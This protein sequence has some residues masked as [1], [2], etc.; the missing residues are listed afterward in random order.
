MSTA[1]AR[2]AHM[3]VTGGAGFIGS[4]L[5]DR[6]VD[7]GHEVTV[8]DS[9][10]SGHNWITGHIEAGRVRFIQADLLDA[11]RL[12][13]AMKGTSVVWH[14]G[15]N[16]DIPSGVNRPDLDLQNAIVATHNVLEAMRAHGVGR[17]VFSSTGAIYGEAEVD[18]IPENYG[19]LLPLS[20][21]AAGKLAA[22]GL[23]ASYC[24]LFGFRARMF[25]FGNVVGARMSHGVTYD[26]IVKLLRN[27]TELEILGDGQ[28]VKS[29]FL[30]EEC[31]DGMFFVVEK[32]FAGD[33]PAVDLLNLGAG[34][35]TTVMDIARIVIE[36]LGLTDVKFR[37]TGGRQG[38]PGD[39]PR[40]RLDVARVNRLGW[41]ARAQ[42]SEAVR[43]AARRIIADLKK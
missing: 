18:P 8:Y 26:F 1:L 31:L 15:G 2:G 35:A 20:L 10:V 3:L 27:P 6:L 33:G 12:R 32:A 16:T 24:S 37:F 36:E 34:E 43:V 11:D 4:H 38:W 39:Q 9:L 30:V 28:G 42:S 22:E 13:S 23:I 19:P 17:L 25:R 29:Y 41:K 21:Y 40:V 14:L 5:V 7:H